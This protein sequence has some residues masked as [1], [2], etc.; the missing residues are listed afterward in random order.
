MNRAC[1]LFLSAAALTLLTASSVAAQS[2]PRCSE[3]AGGQ[4]YAGE[5]NVVVQIMQPVS[6]FTSNI[7]LFSSDPDQNRVVGKS[8]SYKAPPTDLGSFPLGTELVFGI[9]VDQTSQ[10]YEMGPSSRNPDGLFHAKVRCL[11]DGEA[12][13]AFEDKDDFDYNDVV[14]H[15]QTLPAPAQ[16]ARNA[17]F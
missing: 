12:E 1:Q 8:T 11:G 9:V 2:N 13:I 4:F 16:D 14:I 10:V 7:V 15:I 6:F 5:G 3:G 17:A